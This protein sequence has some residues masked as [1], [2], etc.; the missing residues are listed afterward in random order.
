MREGRGPGRGLDIASRRTLVRDGKTTG[1]RSNASELDER[2]ECACHSV[3]RLSFETECAS[4]SETALPSRGVFICARVRGRVSKA[5]VRG[6]GMYIGECEGD[7]LGRRFYGHFTEA[8]GGAST[9]ERGNV[10]RGPYD[11]D[12][13]E[14][15]TP[16]SSSVV[17]LEGFC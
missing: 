3:F 11:T 13:Q 15:G 17:E 5:E 2:E 6:L 16:G 7:R 9:S 10:R 8:A 14:A 12:L 4:R 1:E